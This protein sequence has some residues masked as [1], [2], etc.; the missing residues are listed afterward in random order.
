MSHR[1]DP[2]D[3]RARAR[4]STTSATVETTF[5][6]VPE[7]KAST[8]G[9]P[10]ASV[11]STSS[12]STTPTAP[13]S[14][15]PQDSPPPKSALD[16][17]DSLIKG[18]AGAGGGTLDRKDKRANGEVAGAAGGAAVDLNLKGTVVGLGMFEGGG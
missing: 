16:R 2:F 6:A 9:S 3:P 15:L 17:L 11:R 14:P 4:P 8:A 12:T 5:D 10:R 1:P 13:A 18:G 7:P